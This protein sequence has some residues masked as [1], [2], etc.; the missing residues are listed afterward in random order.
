MDSKYLRENIGDC[1][2][3]CLAEVCE[4]R[5]ADPIE[6]IAQW[7]YKHVDNVEKQKQVSRCLCLNKSNYSSN[8][9]FTLYF[10]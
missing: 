2:S 8:N 7:L 4:K 10:R 3:S 5:P 1:L 9:H 6:Y